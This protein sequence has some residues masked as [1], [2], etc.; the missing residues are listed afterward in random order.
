MS[1]LSTS[2]TYSSEVNSAGQ[3]ASD[4]PA[5]TKV[6]P[7]AVLEEILKELLK[8]KHASRHPSLGSQSPQDNSDLLAELEQNPT[9]KKLI[10]GNFSQ[11]S[12]KDI[13]NLFFIIFA[14]MD[15]NAQS[16]NADLASQAYHLLSDMKICTQ[17]ANSSQDQINK[18]EQQIHDAYEE[19]HKYDWL[20]IFLPIV[21]AVITIVISVVTFGAGAPAAAAADVGVDAAVDAGL[22]AGETELEDLA[23]NEGEKE[24]TELAEEESVSAG[25]KSATSETESMGSKIWNFIK[26]NPYMRAAGKLLFVGGST[27]GAYFGGDSIAQKQAA[28]GSADSAE[29]TGELQ[30]STTITSS[31]IANLQTDIS[32]SQ[33]KEQNEMSE[34]QA[35]RSAKTNMINQMS[36]TFTYQA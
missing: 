12:K 3:T 11:F 20:K 16:S 6:D 5:P 36:K 28:I 2:Y 17:L 25:T 18:A 26:T 22:D 13:E 35:N 8:A 29:A 10:E 24:L 19:A 31:A 21:V 4:S 15:K 32:G 33:Q 7:K 30:S 9:Y 14:A 1:A 34:E 23:A 27:T